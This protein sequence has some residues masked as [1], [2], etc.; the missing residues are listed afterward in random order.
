MM[1]PLNKQPPN[2]LK[3]KTALRE[4]KILLCSQNSWIPPPIKKKKGFLK[5]YA[6]QNKG[7]AI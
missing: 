6:K 1:V 3:T 2:V 4:I 7:L 5:D